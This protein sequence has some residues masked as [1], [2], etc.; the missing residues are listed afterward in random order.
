MKHIEVAAAVLLEDNAVFAAQR[1]HSGP[2]AGR[3][4]FPGGKLEEGEDGTVAI[5]REIEEE[6]KTQIEVV[7]HLITV[8]HQYP[9]FFLTMHAYLCRRIYGDLELSEHIASC[10]IGKD[11][12]LTLDWAEADIPVAREVEKL[13]R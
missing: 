11:D 9:T 5:V 6:L 3:W 1:G 10:L 2:L 4:E 12:L 8:E 7:R 13:L